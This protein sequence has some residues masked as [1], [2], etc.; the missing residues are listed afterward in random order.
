MVVAGGVQ[1]EFADQL[2]GM[3]V[4]DA[5]VQVVDEQQH[6]GA[7]PAGAEADV[8]QPAVVAEGHR[9]V[10]VDGVGSDSVVSGM[11]GPVGAA[12]GRAAYACARVRRPR[13]LCGRRV[14]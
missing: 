13:A 14:L 9:A 10:V 2:A 11:T 8:V 7:A 5:D 3:P 6:G 4:G 1:G 12:F